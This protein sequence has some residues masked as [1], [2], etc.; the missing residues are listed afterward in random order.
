MPRRLAAIVGSL[1]LAAG[2]AASLTAA[3]FRIESK[4]YSGDEETAS[5]TYLTLFHHGVVYDFRGEPAAEVI[6]YDP[7]QGHFTLL[8]VGRKV[9]T[10]I[11]PDVLLQFVAGI[12]ARAS[13]RGDA[14]H[15]EAA[16]P[17]FKIEAYDRQRRIALDGKRIDYV[18]TCEASFPS[19]EEARS[20]FEFAD[21][22]ARLNATQPGQL[23]PQA[24][25][26][27]NAELA[28]R[29]WMPIKVERQEQP[30]RYLFGRTDTAHSEHSVAWQLLD[31][32]LRRI[33]TAARQQGDFQAVSF[34]EYRDL[35]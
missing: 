30:G 16:N 3:D 29:G 35:K 20:Y 15:R 27:V 7:R 4:V 10:R 6:I 19:D 11:S 9:K 28:R 12:A 18:V 25:L 32:D 14:I 2:L 1:A 22:Y 23:P 24:R 17:Q 21:M 8:D 26:A 5:G 13:E 34:A 31:G 33:D